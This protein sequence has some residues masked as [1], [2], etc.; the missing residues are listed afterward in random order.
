MSSSKILKN[1]IYFGVVPKLSTLINILIL[2]IITPFLS[3]FD[4]G[5]SGIIS[6]YTSLIVAIAPL[7]LNVHLTN[8]F[9]E[10]KERYNLVWGR[11]L[12]LF[13]ISGLFLGL[14][15][16]AIL[17][18]T[19]PLHS[20]LGFLLA[21]LGSFQVFFFANSKLAEHLYP[22]LS[23][24]KPLVFT[25]LAASLIG[26]VVS[27]VL[28]YFFKL[29]YWGLVASPAIST[30]S[31]FILFIRPI[32]VKYNIQP[33]IERNKKRLINNIKIALPII[34]HTLGFV[35]LSSSARIVMSLYNVSYD[36]IG[37][38][39]H[40]TTMG[41]YI[42]FITSALVTALLPQVQVAYRSGNYNVYR[43]LFYLCQGVTISTTFLFCVWMP[44]VYDVLIHNDNLR[45]TY[46]IASM[47]CFANV[48]FPFYSFA[49]NVAFIEKKTPQLLWL[50]FIPGGLNLILCA[51]FIP[52]FGYKAA[53][54]S[55][56]ASYWSQIAIPFFIPYFKKTVS[57]W[58]NGLNKIVLLFVLML[59]SLFI[60]NFIMEL[61]LVYK[62]LISL[63]FGVFVLR[64]YYKFKLN[65]IV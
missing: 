59:L 44:Q 48:A 64:Y 36:E 53:I 4:Y 21:I 19:L 34:P 26:I 47:M 29:G 20:S 49:S 42:V 6:S 11:V 27:F 54:Y 35:L 3:T 7:G 5:I 1:T 33:V 40:G 46:V 57:E 65:K 14:I 31:T 56:L 50:V 39:S 51:V 60:G 16:T 23:N 2:P 30:L 18:F 15:N 38:Y 22:L 32:W 62:L 55:T 25:N 43:K 63:L 8:S 9:Y 24:P 17:Y 13:L 45:Q 28:I 10:Y 41:S 37:L 52:I 61:G 12:L 58:L